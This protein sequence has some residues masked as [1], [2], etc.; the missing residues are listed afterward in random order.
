MPLPRSKKG[1]GMTS[2]SRSHKR[3]SAYFTNKQGSMVHV[4][5][6]GHD[7]IASDDIDNGP[8]FIHGGASTVTL[9][10][11]HQST[12]KPAITLVVS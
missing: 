6:T 2:A 8:M 3:E 7:D 5:E 11:N 1:L 10:Q 12:K 4:P 9:P